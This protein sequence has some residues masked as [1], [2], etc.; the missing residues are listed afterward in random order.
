MRQQLFPEAET[1]ITN[2]CTLY[3]TI[4]GFDFGFAL[5]RDSRVREKLRLDPFFGYAC[6]NWG[7][8]ARAAD[9]S[10]QIIHDFLANDDKAKTAAQVL[11]YIQVHDI[12]GWGLVNVDFLTA[13]DLTA[14]FGLVDLIKKLPAILSIPSLGAA[15]LGNALYGALFNKQSD[16]LRFLLDLGADIGA[17]D[18][19]GA[20]PLAFAAELGDV[21]AARLLLDY[22]ADPNA[23]DLWFEAAIVK[24]ASGGHTAVV[25]L[26]LERGASFDDQGHNH[27]SVVDYAVRR[28][29]RTMIRDF[30]ETTTE[31]NR[32]D[33]LKE[34]L[35][36]AALKYKRMECMKMVLEKGPLPEMK[37][38]L[39]SEL[40]YT[41]LTT[42]DDPC[43]E[44][45]E[46]LLKKGARPMK[47]GRFGK[48]TI[49]EKTEIDRQW[50]AAKIPSLFTE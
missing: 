23:L 38:R 36:K 19:W 21:D 39:G 18:R 25:R 42:E 32:Q 27:S 22:G 45:V 28:D 31:P 11:W 29:N 34:L 49:L 44:I 43:M 2:V 5:D 12:G 41:A 24:A 8:H 1:T 35:L 47:K 48:E 13:L 33:Y 30:F 4:D 16:A 15:E 46:L 10:N 9:S 20:E 6:E 3:L 14:Y 40:L 50:L 7:Y 37:E 26:L 17:K